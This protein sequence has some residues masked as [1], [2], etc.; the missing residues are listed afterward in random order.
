MATPNVF[1]VL[2]L[3]ASTASLSSDNVDSIAPL[4]NNLA[5]LGNTELNFVS[6]F[7]FD[8][9]RRVRGSGYEPLKALSFDVEE[10]SC[11]F[12]FAKLIERL[13]EVRKLF[14]TY[15]IRGLLIWSDT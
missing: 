6:D 3:T 15:S 13:S 2:L 4:V 9:Q 14:C 7:T 8:E 10:T 1:H 12:G 5:T 11:T